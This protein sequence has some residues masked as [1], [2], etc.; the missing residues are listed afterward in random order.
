MHRFFIS[1]EA[2]QGNQVSLEERVARQ[3]REVL[4]ARP[5]EHIILLDDEGGEYEAELAWVSREGG[6]ARVVEKRPAPPEPRTQLHLYQSL[7][8]GDKFDLVLQKG[9]EVGIAAFIPVFSLRCV[10]D[11]VRPNKLERWHRILVEAAEQS[12][13]GR[14]PALSEPL[15]FTDACEKVSG[16]SLLPWEGER[17]RG[18]RE[19]LQGAADQTQI[20]LFIGP[21]GGYEEREVAFARE[22]GILPVSLGRRILRAETAGLVAASAIL[23]HRGE[24]EP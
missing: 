22:R 1:P 20:D 3:L 17:G 23:Y 12:G 19:A 24:L 4:R 5:G 21:E 13:R 18:L 10:V 7:L 2:I 14:L 9:T 6:E 8:K 16:L 11:E 15:L